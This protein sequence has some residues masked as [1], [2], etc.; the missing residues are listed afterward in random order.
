MFDREIVRFY[1]LQ[2][3]D[4]YT[5]RGV[6]HYELGNQREAIL[7]YDRAIEIN[8]RCEGVYYNR[9]VAHNE[10]GNRMQAIEDMKTAA[11]FDI[12]NAKNFLKS[13][14]INW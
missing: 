7:D 8:P 10:L 6:A 4:A 1:G 2:G 3:H 12:E 13:Q 11:R 14:G 5:N 9:G